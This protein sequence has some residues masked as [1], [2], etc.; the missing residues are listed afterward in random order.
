MT[1]AIRIDCKSTENVPHFDKIRVMADSDHHVVLQ[2]PGRVDKHLIISQ[3]KASLLE[4][5]VFDSGGSRATDWVTIMPVV[6]R[7]TVLAHS[8][9]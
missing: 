2:F 6:P 8:V 3:L 5:S 4:H 1:T 7:A 9:V